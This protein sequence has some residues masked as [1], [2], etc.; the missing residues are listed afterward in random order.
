MW[1]NLDLLSKHKNVT[2]CVSD[3]KTTEDCNGSIPRNIRLLAG[4]W[5]NTGEQYAESYKKVIYC[6]N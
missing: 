6:R 2:L 4:V 3:T 1:Q 5:R